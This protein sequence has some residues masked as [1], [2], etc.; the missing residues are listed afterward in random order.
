V[1]GISGA[2]ASGGES[3]ARMRHPVRLGEPLRPSALPEG[4]TVVCGGAVGSG[5]TADAVCIM[6]GA[7]HLRRQRAGMGAV[8]SLTVL[9]AVMNLPPDIPVRRAD[10]SPAALA[11]L[12][13]TGA[14]LVV[15]EP[16]WV[17]RIGRPPLTVLGAVVTGMSWRA[18][19]RRAVAFGPFAQRIVILDRAPASIDVLLWEAQLAGVGV[20]LTVSG[21]MS[22][23]M[24]PEPFQLH[25]LKAATWRFAERAYRAATA[26]DPT[27]ALS[28]SA[29]RPSSTGA[30]TSCPQLPQ[31]PYR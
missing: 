12:K 31:L 3:M 7:E 5:A 18:A 9:D 16:D 17:T 23:L 11:R 13:R 22:E 6:D 4:A 27:S 14:G 20:W 10:I 30:A 29:D 24:A 15:V 19:L 21:S 26:S 2:R 8:T 25:F 28:A 1:S